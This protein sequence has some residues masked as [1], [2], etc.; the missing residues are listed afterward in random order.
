[1]MNEE[2][3]ATLK[4]QQDIQLAKKEVLNAVTQN[5]AVNLVPGVRS[6]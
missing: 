2:D 5:T 3:Y 4:E 6:V 1:M